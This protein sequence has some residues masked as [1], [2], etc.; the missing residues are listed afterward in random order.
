MNE[1]IKHLNL[2]PAEKIIFS[3]YDDHYVEYNG[4]E[5]TMYL[6][7]I[8]LIFTSGR[9]G[10]KNFHIEKRPINDIVFLMTNDYAYQN[11]IDECPTLKIRFSDKEFLFEF[12]CDD[13]PDSKKWYDVISE[14]LPKGSKDD[15]FCPECGAFL[16]KQPGFNTNANF[17]DCVYCGTRSYSDNVYSGERYPDYY[18]YCDRCNSLMNIQP[19]FTDTVDKWKCKKCGYLN[20]IFVPDEDEE[21]FDDYQQTYTPVEKNQFCIYC[22]KKLDFDDVFCTNCGKKIN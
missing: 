19:D 16:K 13:N 7:N 14:K 6:T 21:E 12:E 8:N 2:L 18:W 9:Y 10:R 17:W 1:E 20:S 22:G 11:N 5:I 3:S 15:P 4:M